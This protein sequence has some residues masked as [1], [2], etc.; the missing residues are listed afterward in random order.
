MSKANVSW[1]GL[2][3][4][5]GRLQRSV[6]ESTLLHQPRASVESHDFTSYK[7]EMTPQ[8][9]GFTSWRLDQHTQMRFFSPVGKDHLHKNCRLERLTS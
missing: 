2:I 1:H 4:K 6:S 7:A 8:T 9:N 3:E 5:L